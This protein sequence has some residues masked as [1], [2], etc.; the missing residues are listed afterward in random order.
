MSPGL[1]VLAQFV[2]AIRDAGY[3]GTPAAVAELVDN[4]LEA[5]ATAIEIRLQE[6]GDDVAISVRD[7]GVGMTPQTLRV[8]LRFGGTTRFNSRNGVGRY[9]M[10]LPNSS[11]SQA[12]RVDVSTWQGRA[13]P[14]GTYLDIDDVVAG[15]LFDIPAPVARPAADRLP[16]ASGTIV[17]WTK[18]DRLDT[19]HIDDLAPRLAA[20]LGRAFRHHLWSGKRIGIN[21]SRVEPRDPLFVHAGANRRGATLVGSPLTF[22]LRV[23][24]STKTSRVSVT[25]SELP[26]AR[27][28]SLSNQE[29][30]ASGIAKGAGIS[31]VRAGR[32]ID[33]GWHFMGTKRRENYDDWWR[34]EVRFDPELDELFGVTHTKQGIHP[35]DDLKATLSPDLE[36]IA[37][38]LNARIRHQFQAVT[39]KPRRSETIATQRDASLEP[40]LPS[41]YHTSRA[42]KTYH[43][44]GNGGVTYRVEEQSLEDLNFFLPRITRE[45][46][47]V[48]L[49]T[50]H[51]F[52][53]RAYRARDVRERSLLEL[54]LFAA[55][56]AESSLSG[57]TAQSVGRKFREAW[58]NALAAFLA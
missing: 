3:R 6:K 26:V 45:E 9:G 44:S 50:A 49:N 32:E 33:F 39:R 23:P 16:S 54:V 41:A 35:T 21:G 18:C 27:W 51:P 38:Q 24:R 20:S 52:Y 36:G 47:V 57:R 19:N 48:L 29:K 1:V 53:E 10:G 55:A 46:I 22:D 8:A 28:V 25:F 5:D 31:I 56:R 30:R 2:Q 14:H 40:P 43:P 58:S 11:V 42:R 13:T 34:C 7:N 12:R 17:T 15:K 37:H 4:A